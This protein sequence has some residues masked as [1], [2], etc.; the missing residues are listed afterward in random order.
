[1]EK[2][3]KSSTVT[4]KQK[5]KN[6][7]KMIIDLCIRTL[8]NHLMTPQIYLVTIRRDPT[9]SLGTTGLNYLTVH[10]VVQIG[11]TLSSSSSERRVRES[12]TMVQMASLW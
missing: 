1:M 12:D 9:P 10:K 7:Q 6:V 5:L 3:T 11:S 8:F 2:L 4:K